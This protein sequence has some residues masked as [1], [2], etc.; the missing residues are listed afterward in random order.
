MHRVV[1][2]L[3]ATAENGCRLARAAGAP[4]FFAS[5]AFDCRRRR[6]SY[7]DQGDRPCSVA[8]RRI[9]L[10]SRSAV[11]RCAA[12]PFEPTSLPLSRPS[13]SEA[14][15]STPRERDRKECGS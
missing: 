11:A 9:D 10:P 4:G 15:T 2:N 14:R 3:N 13:R 5:G 7:S 1:G 8:Y 12:R 6:A